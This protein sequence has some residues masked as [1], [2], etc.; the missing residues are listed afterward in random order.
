VS[1]I[2]DQ[3]FERLVALYR[4][5]TGR[6]TSSE[7]MC[8]C[9]C[10]AMKVANRHRLQTGD[11][12]SC[13]CLKREHSK[14]MVALF[15]REASEEWQSLLDTL[16][17]VVTRLPQRPRE[18]FAALCATWGECGDRRFRRALSTLVQQGRVERR[19]KYR[20]VSDDH[21]S[22][23][24]RAVPWHRNLASCIAEAAAT[25]AVLERGVRRAA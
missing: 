6:N 19:G 10:G 13:G 1:D 17:E 9:D 21:A 15:Q 12:K 22:V 16:C 11:T 20:S 4:V 24:V 25:Y 5:G 2:T 3:R 8:R 18:L 7:W 23:Y 14:R